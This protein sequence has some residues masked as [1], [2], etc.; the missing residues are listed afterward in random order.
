VIDGE[1]IEVWSALDALVLKAIAIVL[2]RRWNT[3]CSCFAPTG[4]A[5]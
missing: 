5:L 3:D 2:G 4:A 1:A